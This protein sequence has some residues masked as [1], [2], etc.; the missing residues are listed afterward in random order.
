MWGHQTYFS[1]SSSPLLFLYSFPLVRQ[2]P[3]AFLVH[4][5][6]LP[7]TVMSIFVSV[8]LSVNWQVIRAYL[9][10]RY[11]SLPSLFIFSPSPPP[12]GISLL[13]LP[14]FSY[15][16]AGLPSENPCTSLQEKTRIS[17]KAE[18]G[19]K[20]LEEQVKVIIESNTVSA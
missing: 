12:P 2:T 9:L 13:A 14:S 17:L 1:S 7:S 20:D 16:S 11:A 19:E 8:F 5:I 4:S 18:E 15:L 6:F 10:Y 3:P